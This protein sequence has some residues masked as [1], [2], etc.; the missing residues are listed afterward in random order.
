MEK[1]HKPGL[2]GWN[3]RDLLVTAIIAIVFALLLTGA[4]YLLVI[5]TPFGPL[6][7]QAISGLWVIPGLITAYILRRPGAALLSQVL[8]G[9]I[10][11]PL[12][13]YGWMTVV[14]QLTYGIASELVFLVTRYRNYSLPVMLVA[15]AL[16]N[17][18]NMGLA[19]LAL[20]Y[21]NLSTG[22][23]IAVVALT[24][25]SGALS[26]WLSKALTDAIA[27]TGVLNNFAIGQERMEEI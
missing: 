6:A 3:T 8:V 13:P 2:K 5:I 16:T 20:G 18:F 19:Y 10:Q 27:K 7:V 9:I 4:N 14:G 15:G 22:I 25:L 1:Q 24:L 11:A 17:L 12:S 21:A 23:Q 26:G